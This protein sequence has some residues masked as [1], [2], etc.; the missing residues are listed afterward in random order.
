M[1]DIA[2]T[3]DCV[4]INVKTGDLVVVSVYR[5]TWGLGWD[6]AYLSEL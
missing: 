1:P 5:A 4:W 6:W 2:L 3:D